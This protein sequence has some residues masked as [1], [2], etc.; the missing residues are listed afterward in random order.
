MSAGALG[1][2]L[3]DM[4]GTL[5]DTERQSGEA[6]GDVFA[7]RYGVDLGPDALDQVLGAAWDDALAALHAQHRLKE[8][9]PEGLK[10]A[11]LTAKEAAL[12]GRLNVLPGARAALRAAASRWPVAVVTGSWRVEAEYALTEMGVSDSVQFILASEDV[13]EGKPSP[14][15]YAAAAARLGLPPQRCMVLEDS[16]R[17]VAAALGAG[18]F[19]VGLRAGSL[20]PADLEASGAHAVLDSLV[21]LK[22]PKAYEE[23]YASGKT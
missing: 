9:D 15:G 13:E 21:G 14:E 11:L 22:R 7:T 12:A 6:L 23:L 4:D 5:V 2:V 16:V 17:G 19:T 8:R 18:A 20:A 1:A 10:R 3:F